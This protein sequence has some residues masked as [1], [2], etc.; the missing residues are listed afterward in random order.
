MRIIFL[1]QYFMPESGAT[2]EL[3]S[4]IAVGLKRRGYDV[5]AIAGQPSYFG[6]STLPATLEIDGVTV[7]RVWSTQLN[8]NSAIGRIFNSASFVASVFLALLRESRQSL[9]V[10][11]TNPPLL[12]WVCHW[13][14]VLTRK[15]YVLVIHDVYP[16]I[17]VAL[18]ALKK[19]GFVARLW[20]TFNRLS[21]ARAEHI[22]VLG[23][24]MREKI[25][26]D[27]SPGADQR[28]S[29]ID[30]WADDCLIVPVA[31]PGHPLLV[32]Y[33]LADRFV[34]QYSGNIGRF[35]EIET[36]LAA[37]K[38]L[39]GDGGFH[40]LFFGEGKQVGEVKAAEAASRTA[41]VSL[42]PFQN[43]DQLGTSL[44][45]CDVGLVTLKDG[46]SGL[47]VPS[48]LYGVLAAGKPVVVVGPES[49]EAARLIHENDCGI[50]VRPGDAG[51]LAAALRA[52]R[53]DPARCERLGRNSRALFLAQFTY[54][55]IVAEWAELFAGLAR[56]RA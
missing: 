50:V 46:L 19:D 32:Q 42:K 54:D 44:T 24:D 38:D 4:G 34:V 23:R 6:A 15:R 28:I 33:G 26:A 36:I 9:I 7:R 53:S 8:K 25:L 51:A 13:A 30:N 2:S 17:A 41:S 37:A 22:V 31:R 10:A 52:L 21:Y 11:V 5:G 18:N 49:C 40:F 47:A 45:A 3:L 14:H 56:D 12:P 43:R 27:A 29:I 20:S 55:R 16:D 1:S 35:H 39:D 48:K